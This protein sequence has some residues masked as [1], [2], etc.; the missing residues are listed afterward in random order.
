MSD[1]ELLENETLIDGQDAGAA[2]QKKKRTKSSERYRQITSVQDTPQGPPAFFTPATDRR[3]TQ[4]DMDLQTT[5]TQT[6]QT[7]FQGMC[8]MQSKVDEEREE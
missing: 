6:V 3:P 4:P 8:E 7:M 1:N 2:R 5:M